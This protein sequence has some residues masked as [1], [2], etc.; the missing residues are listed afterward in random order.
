MRRFSCL[1]CVFV[2]MLIDY[3][4]PLGAEPLDDYCAWAA[5]GD[6]VEVVDDVVLTFYP[7]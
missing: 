6:N 2:K 5:A 7:V 4:R 1:H 3:V